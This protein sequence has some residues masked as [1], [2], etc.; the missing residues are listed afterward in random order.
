[1]P[2][3][4][5]DEFAISFFQEQGFTRRKCPSC[6][7]DYWSSN[8]D[9]A[10]CGEVPCEPYHFIGNPPTKVHYDV[11][12]MRSHFLEFF[13]AN[14][15][16]KIRPYPIVARWRDDV[17]LVGASIYDFQPYVTEGIMPPPANPLV[18]SQP[19]IRFTDI[20]AAGLTAGRHGTIFE[21][22][23]AHAFNYPNNEV[24]WK[25]QTVRYHH[26]LLTDV[27]GVP[28]N[29]VSYK[30]HFWSGGGN[31]GPDLEAI[32]SGLE[33]STL[34]FM[35]YK[36][37]GDQLTQLP[38]RTVDT[39]YGIERWAWLSTGSPSGFHTI[40]GS[41]LQEI[42]D[43][44]KLRI[45]EKTI[46]TF[47]QYYGIYHST[48][49]ANRG[50]FLQ[51]VATETGQD[52]ARV[53]EI[54]ERLEAVYALTDH[55]KTLTFLLAEG[56]VPSNVGEGYLARLIIRRAARLVRMLD[57]SQQLPTIVDGQIKLW[58]G[59]FHVLREMKS[60]ILEALQVEM[61]K[62]QDTLSRGSDIVQRL[63]KE[64]ASTGV[65]QIP[66]EQL[67]QLYDSQGLAPEIVK[68]EAEKVGVQVQIPDNFLTLVAERH[69]RPKTSAEKETVQTSDLAQTL[70]E[71]APTRTL[72]YDDAYQTS[73]KA[74]VVAMP[75]PDAVVLD[76]TAF[77]PQGGGQPGDRG[78]LK[79][80]SGKAKVTDV[81]KFGSTIVHFL[82]QSIGPR[83]DYVEGEIDWARRLNLMRHHTGTHILL[84]AARKVLGEHV[85][86]AGAA[87]EVEN[88]RLDITHYQELSPRER[89]RIEELANHTIMRDLPVQ[90]NWMAREKAESKYGYRLYQGG[91]VPGAKIRVVRIV[92]WDAEAC[93]GTHVKHT[94]ELGL[95]KIEKTDRLQDGV[96]RIIFSAGE[97]AL[98][99]VN[100]GYEN[101]V[102]T[103][104]L[105]NTTPEQLPKAVKSL[106]TEKE[107]LEKRIEKSQSKSLEN[108]LRQIQKSAIQIGPV[109]LVLTK[110]PKTQG[111]DPVQIANKL[112]ESDP[113]MVIVIFEIADSVQVIA[114]AGDLAVEA[115]V[116]CGTIV[117]LAARAVHGGGGGRPFFASGGGPAKDK[118]AE[119]MKVVEQTI[120]A[121]LQNIRTPET[122]A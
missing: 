110:I 58:G 62:Y 57:I 34:V 26:Q 82:D 87:K 55:T 41:L 52:V 90:I 106:L 23:G 83:I 46:A 68:E 69:N 10:N 114:A 84:G 122:V 8:P 30:E 13:A 64:L 61:R 7:S 29:A 96:E 98:R 103:S 53:A 113:N 119:A 44:A 93:G 120:A 80:A 50:A 92:G 33:I 88:S 73:F 25:D 31:A 115:G 56:V 71:L 85:W 3:I 76:Q 24:Y 21:M 86:Q 101:L 74:K 12:E 22:G 17:Y 107:K 118:L 4:S 108:K 35:Q 70:G 117:S 5:A 9:Q 65:R 6:A 54:A 63:S 47:S 67:I 32:V 15:H 66:L 105:L 75:R 28:S 42:M 27:M 49:K 1:M 79:F 104:Q 20:E 36:V 43:L 48:V 19:S 102:K 59:D 51:S 77:Y 45:D 72:Y 112:K 89:E 11:P 109:K 116:D 18:I 14:G 16:T 40:Y 39:G 78:E 100:K 94:G 111:I 38:I 2:Q 81:Q 121:Q 60:E 37:Q 99:R 95:F 97:P 91:A